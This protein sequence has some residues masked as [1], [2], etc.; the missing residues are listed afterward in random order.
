[1]GASLIFSPSSWKGHHPQRRYASASCGRHRHLVLR[2]FQCQ[3]RIRCLPR[4]HR[5]RLPLRMSGL[6]GKCPRQTE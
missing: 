4:P 5:R 1:M 3:N 6:F 2:R